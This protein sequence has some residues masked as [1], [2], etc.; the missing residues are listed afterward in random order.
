MMKK[1]RQYIKD[2]DLDLFI[3]VLS[4]IDIYVLVKAVIYL[5]F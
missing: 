2:H 5:Y 3:I 4:A 1:F